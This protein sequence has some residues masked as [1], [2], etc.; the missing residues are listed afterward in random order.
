M[1]RALRVEELARAFPSARIGYAGSMSTSVQRRPTGIFQ[2]DALLD[3]G[4]AMGGCVEV[5]ETARGLGGQVLL[6]ALLRMSRR[7][8]AFLALID[9]ADAFDPQSAR[10]VELQSLLWVR[11]VGPRDA[12]RVADI[13]VRDENFTLVVVDFRDEGHNRAAG[14]LP[15]NLWQRLSRAVR[16]GGCCLVT[17]S[18][19]PLLPVHRQRVGISSRFSPNL[20]DA[21]FSAVVRTLGITGH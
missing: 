7:E 13:L 6:H 9:P 11:G 19:K 5:I 1:S 10:S 4:L 8:A 3:G 18:S 17:L 12:L 15:S 20:L 21:P 14:R 16:E 2:L